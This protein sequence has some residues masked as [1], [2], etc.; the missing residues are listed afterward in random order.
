MVSLRFRLGIIPLTAV[1]LCPSAHAQL[2]LISS[3]VELIGGAGNDNYGSYTYDQTSL[4][5]PGSLSF[6]LNWPGY[7]GAYADSSGGA[8]WSATSTDLK[9]G[10][11]S[12]ETVTP[13][14]S[15]TNYASD[16]GFHVIYK[17]V[18]SVGQ[19]SNLTV[20]AVNPLLSG[21]SENGSI[22]NGVQTLYSWSGTSNS[23]SPI[24][25]MANQNYTVSYGGLFETDGAEVNFNGQS[26]VTHDFAAS[27][28]VSVQ[29]APEPMSILG[30][31]LGLVALVKRRLHK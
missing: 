25:L 15:Y 21:A 9:F 16:A 14:P 26:F 23:G 31:S 11:S 29:P 19:A 4:V 6:D 10:D 18:F 30:L 27:F 12:A 17:V 2:T 1:L 20:S 22:S 24:A 7:Q 13:T 3:S 28:D 5:S 8:T